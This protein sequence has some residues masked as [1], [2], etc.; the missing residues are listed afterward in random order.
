MFV[1]VYYR[2]DT[3]K[4]TSDCVPREEGPEAFLQ[5]L[6]SPRGR[7]VEV[8]CVNALGDKLQGMRNEQ[9][10]N[11]SPHLPVLQRDNPGTHWPQSL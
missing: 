2:T 10:V 9:L 8:G 11:E 1:L 7:D 3:E 4:L 6:L 5:S